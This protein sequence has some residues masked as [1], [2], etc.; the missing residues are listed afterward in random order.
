[1]SILHLSTRILYNLVRV[2]SCS[3]KPLPSAMFTG[4]LSSMADFAILLVVSLFC[5]EWSSQVHSLWERV[6]ERKQLPA[7]CAGTEFA[8]PLWVLFVVLLLVLFP[9][10]KLISSVA[11]EVVH[12]CTVVWKAFYIVKK[13]NPI[14]DVD[15]KLDVFYYGDLFQ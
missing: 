10:S 5:L 2:G 12:Y 1:M 8:L 9:L 14:G 13:L 3:L 15:G 7:T 4:L 11:Q 6:S